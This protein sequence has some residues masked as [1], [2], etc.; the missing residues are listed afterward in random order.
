[1]SLRLIKIDLVFFSMR[2]SPPASPE[3]AMAGRLF[4]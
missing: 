2:S 3:V 4:R 1:M